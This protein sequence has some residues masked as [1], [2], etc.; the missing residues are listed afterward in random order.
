MATINFRKQGQYAVLDMEYV[1]AEY[2][3]AGIH[4]QE[5][6]LDG[7]DFETKVAENGMALVISNG[8][9]KFP[10]AIGDHVVVMAT[11][12]ELYEEGK[13][14]N[15]FCIKRGKGSQPRLMELV[16]GDI[17]S[18]NAVSYDDAEFTTLENLKTAIKEGTVKAVPATDKTGMWDIT[19][20]TEG[21]T[22]IGHVMDVVSLS[23]G[24]I[25]LRI[26]F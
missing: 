3:G 17:I 14:R 26:K 16:R 2:S 19:K 9:V 15:S 12:C 18:T 10:T 6:E 23:N 8:K 7:T 20:T 11:E 24:E 13:G 21:A 1:S 22:V 5:I 4:S 25:G